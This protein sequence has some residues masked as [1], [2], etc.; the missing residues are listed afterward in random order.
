MTSK[1]LNEKEC[2]DSDIPIQQA[3]RFNNQVPAGWRLRQLGLQSA[4]V[5]R[6]KA[7]LGQRGPWRHGLLQIVEI[8]HRGKRELRYVRQ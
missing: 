2:G 4:P 1:S 7:T 5:V 6:R 3:D 8:R